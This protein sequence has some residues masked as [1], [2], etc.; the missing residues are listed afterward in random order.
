MRVIVAVRG[1]RSA[2]A[3]LALMVA[4]LSA[5]AAIA[6]AHAESRSLQAQLVELVGRSGFTVGVHVQHLPGGE[7]GEVNGARPF[8][9]ASTFKLP[10]AVVALTLVERGEL[11]PLTGEVRLA[12]TDMV[13]WASPLHARMPTGGTATLRE[14]LAALLQHSDNSAADFLIRRIGGPARVTAELQKLGLPGISIDRNE[15]QIALD[16]AGAQLPPAERTAARLQ[17]VLSRVPPAQKQ[18]ALRRFRA[19][20]RDRATPRAMARVIERLWAGKLLSPPH[21]AFLREQLGRC[22]TGLRRLRA[23]VPAGTPVADRTGTC[24]FRVE[25]QAARPPEPHRGGFKGPS[26]GPFYGV[27][28][29]G[30]I[31][32]KDGQ[33]VIA[34]VFVEDAGGPPEPK[35]RV[36]AAVAR[37]VWE[38][39]A[40]GP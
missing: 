13:P 23:G 9:M 6:P 11:P 8:A 36:I 10:L 17:A 35:E 33:Q 19:D 16:A 1:R 14:V 32:F 31:T 20:P 24:G 7:T 5:A 22:Q 38:R 30:I 26:Q 28:D 21:A 39:H 2:R 29:V 40:P 25:A 37:L 15:A 12:T 3:I 4:A 34:A 27:N 18:T